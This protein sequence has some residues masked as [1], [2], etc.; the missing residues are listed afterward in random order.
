MSGAEPSAQPPSKERRRLVLASASPQRRAILTRLGALFEVR[1]SGAEELEAGDPEQVAT[2]NALRKARAVRDPGRDELV[3]GVD[4]LVA[5]DGDVYGKP[6]DRAHA[7]RTLQAL[8][9]RTHTVLSGLAL[10]DA[11]G[12]RTGLART[13]VS[14]RDLSE[15]TIDWYLAREEWCGRAGGYAIQGAGAALVRAIE[16]DYENVVGL[17]LA[18]LLDLLP[19]LL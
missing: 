4:T 13:E 7:R 2:E 14:F 16:G 9:G 17:P 5:L 11:S 3:L 1:P 18:L 6:A 12:E 10:L 19:D 8:S 15:E